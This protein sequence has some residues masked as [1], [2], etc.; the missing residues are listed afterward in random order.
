MSVNSPTINLNDPKLNTP[1]KANN[2]PAAA[3]QYKAAI[4]SQKLQSGHFVVNPPVIRPYSIYDDIPNDDK[5]FK[6]LLK[7]FSKPKKHSFEDK[8]KVNAEKTIKAMF[9]IAATIVCII[10]RKAIKD[11]AVKYYDK[12]KQ[13]FKKR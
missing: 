11:F 10:K 4:A 1:P 6:S 2:A 9:I 12:I 8:T 3:G 13:Y 7:E 5:F